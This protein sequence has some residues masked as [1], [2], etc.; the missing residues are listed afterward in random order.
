M[1]FLLH[2]SKTTKSREFLKI[3]F[4]YLLAEGPG[5]ARGKKRFFSP[6]HPKATLSV[7]KKFKPIRSSR[8]A[9]YREHI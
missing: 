6:C 1:H 8:L 2:I 5:V 9:G 7:L 3:I 4:Y